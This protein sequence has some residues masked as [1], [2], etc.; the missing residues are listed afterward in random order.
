[1][2]EFRV[3]RDRVRPV[4]RY[5]HTCDRRTKLRQMHDLATFIL[6]FHFFPRVA[7]FKKRVDVREKIDRNGVRIN[8]SRSWFC[9][10]FL[11]R[12]LATENGSLGEGAWPRP[13]LSFLDRALG[14]SF[15]FVDR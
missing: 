6:H 3:Y 11:L 12:R 15:Q 14:L 10:R 4:N 5:A 9:R 8:C 2:L 1:M 13:R 7:A